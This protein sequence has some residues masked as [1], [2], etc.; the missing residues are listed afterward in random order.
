MP[1][2]EQKWAR[3]IYKWKCLPVIPTI[4]KTF[5][6]A[7]DW[8]EAPAPEVG[9]QS[10]LQPSTKEPRV[11]LDIIVWKGSFGLQCVSI[12]T[13]LSL[14]S[15]KQ[16][17]TNRTFLSSTHSSSWTRYLPLIHLFIQLDEVP[18]SH[19]LIHPAGQ[20]TTLCPPSLSLSFYLSFSLYLSL[21]LTHSISLFLYLYHFCF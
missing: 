17:D 8:M 19:P 9:K 16:L 3:N 21:S 13:Q 5:V 14:L 1:Q 20:G 2:S 12:I 11:D 4:K 10:A 6:G 18:S 15:S 7:T